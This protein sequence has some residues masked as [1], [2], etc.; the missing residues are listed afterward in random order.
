MA[1]HDLEVRGLHAGTDEFRVAASAT[2]FYA[3][4][5]IMFA[6]TYTNGVA[7]VNTVVVLTDAKPV[8]G[9]DNFVGIAAKDAEVNSSATVT[10]HKTLVT[11]Y[12]P[13]IT[14][15]WGKA[16]VAASVDTDSEL[17]G[18]LFDYVLFDLTSTAYTIDETAAAD[19]SAL[20]IVNGNIAR[21]LLGV[22]V[23]PRG[24]RADIS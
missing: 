6:G 17:L 23:D 18:V 19:T 16:K 13:N 21:G 15:I 4:E 10:A 2:R 12:F 20:K 14:Q 1:K 22:V 9:T 7:S 24:D 8:I 5:P 3:G 11:R